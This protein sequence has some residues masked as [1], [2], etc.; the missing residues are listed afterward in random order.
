MVELST[1]IWKFFLPRRGVSCR[2]TERPAKI[3]ARIPCDDGLLFLDFRKLR[4]EVF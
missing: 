3:L 4:M 2:A 1:G